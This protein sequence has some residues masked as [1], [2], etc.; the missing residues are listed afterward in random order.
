MR[1]DTRP[2]THIE[3]SDQGAVFEYLDVAYL[4]LRRSRERVY[5]CDGHIHG[6]AA[7]EI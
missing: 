6:M 7:R 5:G 2:M 4:Q 3:R 1:A